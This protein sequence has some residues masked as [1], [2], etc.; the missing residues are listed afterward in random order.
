M[1]ATTVKRA[2]A[3]TEFVRNSRRAFSIARR[4]IGVALAFIGVC[5][6]P[7]C[8]RH[9]NPAAAAQLPVLEFADSWGTRG[10]APG[11]LES[12]VGIAVDG[13]GDVYIA[14]AA[15]HSINKFSAKGGPLLSFAYPAL[16]RPGGIAVDRGGGI[17]TSVASRILVYW[18][19][20]DFLRATHGGPRVAFRDASGI[21][22]GDEG[23][24][25]V[26]D[27]AACRVESFDWHGKFK[28]AWGKCGSE[29]GEFVA[30]SGA[31]VDREGSVFVAD[32]GGAR[33]QKFSP[34]GV[35]VAAF[36]QATPAVAPTAGAPAPS[37]SDVAAVAVSAKNIFAAG[38]AAS[39]L[40]AW[41]LDGTELPLDPAVLQAA[42]L[43]PDFH[44]SALAYDLRS[45]DLLL[46]DAQA[47]RVLRIHVHL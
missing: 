31:A 20:G 13:F 7:G 35:F 19:E 37:Q 11:Q 28:R 15:T 5:F 40:R 27:R 36:G 22:V 42:H 38:D 10:T 18:P 25:Y 1:I 30:P 4:R 2:P 46:L 23:D 26:V 41:S 43:T 16:T 29:N 17:Y 34:D 9:A 39:P 14:D 33:V 47:C 6:L 8:D 21:A 12:P 24:F 32:A 3:S 44:P 45:G